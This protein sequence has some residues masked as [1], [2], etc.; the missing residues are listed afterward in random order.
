MSKLE[1][2]YRFA[3]GNFMN[4][5]NLTDMDDID[6]M[7]E[8]KD[9]PDTF[10]GIKPEKYPLIITLNKFLMMLDGTLGNSYFERFQDVISS[11][12]GGIRSVALETF[13]RNN[14]VTFDRFLSSYWPHFNEN[15]RKN[16][17]PSRVF[18]EIMSHIKGGLQEGEESDTKRSKQ[19]YLSLSDS[20]AST[21]SVDK[22]EVIYDIFNDY[23]RMK[24]ERREFD[25]ADFVLDIHRRVKDGNV[26]G[27]KMDFVYIDEVQDFTMRQIC[28]FK[29]ICSNIDEGY[30][31][32]GDTAQT[33]ARGI[34]FRFEDIRSLFYNEFFMKSKNSQS[35]RRKEKGVISDIVTLSQNFRTHTGVLRL[36]Q[37]V[38]DLISYF[39]PQSI[40]V[41][42]P[43][44]SLIYGEPPIFLEPGS[45][46]NSIISIFRNSASAGEKWIGF[47]ADQVILVRDD[48]EKKEISNYLGHQALILTIVE[49]KGLEFQVGKVFIFVCFYL[50]IYSL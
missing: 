7:A 20:R 36:A 31:F 45:D 50:H 10:V 35:S 39:F 9:I 16:L 8:F 32:S 34:D 26:P 49:C 15:L 1:Y 11:R 44:T 47:G 48:S 24:M 17:D 41:L 38:T 30:V 37:S 4:D 43:E 19:A 29:Y 42:T 28:L 2:I 33:I 12:N 18:T 21:L 14:E 40:D 3:T 5:D 25:L 13:I 23:E 6:E 22:R 27:D 46:E